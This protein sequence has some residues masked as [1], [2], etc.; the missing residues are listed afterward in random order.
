MTED[1]SVHNTSGE[2]AFSDIDNIMNWNTSSSFEN[3]APGFLTPSRARTPSNRRSGIIDKK[4]DDMCF[5]KLLA[6]SKIPTTD[7]NPI[8]RSDQSYL[9]LSPA[10]SPASS[11]ATSLDNKVNILTN[12]VINQFYLFSQF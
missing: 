11:F 5:R 2:M 8:S 9:L 12:T 10:L 6:A 1:T 3:L 7:A 4:L